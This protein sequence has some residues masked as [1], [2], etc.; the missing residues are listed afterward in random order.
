M[1][2]PPKLAPSIHGMAVLVARYTMANGLHQSVYADLDTEC[3]RPTEDL[4]RA[5][6]PLFNQQG[7]PV[8]ATAIFGRM[9]NDPDFEHSI[10]NAWMASTP[11]HRFF[12]AA[13]QDFMDL[14]NQTTREGREF[15]LPES[16]TGPVVLRDAL[17]RYESNKVLHGP[18]ISDAVAGLARGGPFPHTPAEE[19]RVLLLPSHALY[20][21]S[22]AGGGEDVRDMCWVLNDGFDAG[23]CKDALD[24]RGRGSISITYWSHTHSPTGHEEENM[25]HITG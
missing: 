15:P 25:K 8:P 13:L 5:H 9:G 11:G 18:G 17:A 24:T 6:G 7:F 10:P 23:R 22:W 16:M 1:S 19:A 12:L 20:A 4:Q 3:L 21:Y 2:A 14:Y